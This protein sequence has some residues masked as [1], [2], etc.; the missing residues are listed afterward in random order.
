M[1]DYD[2]GSVIRWFSDILDAKSTIHGSNVRVFYPDGVI[3]DSK[4][5]VKNEGKIIT[6]EGKLNEYYEENNFYIC[7]IGADF[8]R[9]YLFML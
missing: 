3:P 5:L 7:D 1:G 8:Y 4:L 9:V 6:I 2:R